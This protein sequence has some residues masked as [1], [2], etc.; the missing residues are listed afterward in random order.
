LPCHAELHCH[1]NVVIIVDLGSTNGTFLNHERL[2]KPHLMRP[3]DQIRIGQH[4]ASAAFRDDGTPEGL[5]A[6]YSDS[7]PLTCDLRLDSVDHHAV[8]QY[9]VASRLNT[10]L[11][12]ETAMPEVSDI[13]RVAMCATKCELILAERFNQLSELGFP[14]SIARQATEQHSVIII[15]DLATQTDH[16]LGK[17]GPFAVRTII[18]TSPSQPGPAFSGDL[19]RPAGAS[20]FAPLKSCPPRTCRARRL[21]P[22][23]VV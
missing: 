3:E 13:M 6:A 7:R 2:C 1:A 17:S 10:I 14:T 5:I 22:S 12:L 16:T 21:P 11:D 8:L 9:E 15:P 23:V 20:N 4:I 19:E 18:R